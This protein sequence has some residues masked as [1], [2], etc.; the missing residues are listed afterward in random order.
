MNCIKGQVNVSVQVSPE[1]WSNP[2]C[3]P[4]CNPASNPANQISACT[5][6]I[7]SDPTSRSTTLYIDITTTYIPIHEI[8][9]T[10]RIAPVCASLDVEPRQ[11]R[12]NVAWRT[13][14]HM[15]IHNTTQNVTAIKQITACHANSRGT[16][17]T[18]GLVSNGATCTN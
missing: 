14:I 12:Q 15:P 18:L 11:A 9:S 10:G 7:S 17:M 3:N 13:V 8:A 5:F 16:G 2:A 4:A 6:R 1:C